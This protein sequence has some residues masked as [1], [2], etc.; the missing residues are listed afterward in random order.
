MSIFR[1][2]FL[3][4][5]AGI[6]ILFVQLSNTPCAMPLVLDNGQ[7]AVVAPIDLTRLGTDSAYQWQVG[8][9]VLFWLP[10][11]I[12]F[13]VMGDVSIKDFL[14]AKDCS[15]VRPAGPPQAG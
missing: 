14:F 6:A 10:R 12:D 3:Y 8:M 15:V 1:L 4:V 11:M 13:V 9:D 2:A 7:Q 5:L